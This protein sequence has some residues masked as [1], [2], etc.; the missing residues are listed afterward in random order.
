MKKLMT[1]TAIAAISAGAAF[2]LWTAYR[3]FP[4]G[5]TFLVVVD[6]GVGSARHPIAVDAGGFRFVGPDN[7]VFGEVLAEL[8]D[9]QAAAIDIT[10]AIPEGLSGTFHGRDLFAPTA[11]R[12]ACGTPLTEIGASLDR[13]VPLPPALLHIADQTI[14][15]EIIY[16]DHF[17]NVV[18]SIGLCHWQPD[19]MLRLTPRLQP[20]AASRTLDP[21]QVTIHA[22]GRTY[23]HIART[24][25]AVEP[26]EATALINSA[27]ML[28]IAVNQGSARQT[29][30]LAPGDRITVR[31]TSTPA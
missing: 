27:G 26:G 13:L 4:A 21:A 7:G 22:G 8:G 24:Y 23:T 17:G 12:L 11:A 29:L 25:A 15:G 1:A 6:P 31:L 20:D 28:E 10:Q 14:D 19:G 2:A 9:F 18:S 30:G 5:T 16:I 3:Y